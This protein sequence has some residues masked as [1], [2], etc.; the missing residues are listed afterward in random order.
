M[1]P[2]LIRLFSFLCM[3]FFSTIAGN[4]Q[5]FYPPCELSVSPAERRTN[6][7]IHSE[8]LAGIAVASTVKAKS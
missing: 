3:L 4:S 8:L 6:K 1:L 2:T 5:H 7:V